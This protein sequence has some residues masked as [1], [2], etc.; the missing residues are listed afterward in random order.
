[1]QLTAAWRADMVDG[2]AGDRVRKRRAWGR[3]GHLKGGEKEGEA[4]Q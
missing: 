1:M 3:C 4:T 2:W